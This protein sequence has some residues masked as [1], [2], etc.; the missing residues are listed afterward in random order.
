[1]AAL[2]PYP[3]SRWL[4]KLGLLLEKMY[5]TILN[6]ASLIIFLDR[7]RERETRGGRGK[8]A[9]WEDYLGFRS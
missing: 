9:Q 5:L 3:F 7:A 4:K 8:R 1:M 2:G 6:T